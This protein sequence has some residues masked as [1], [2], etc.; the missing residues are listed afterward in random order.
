MIGKTPN[1]AREVRSDSRHRPLFILLLSQ[2]YHP[3]PLHSL[4]QFKNYFKTVIAKLF[5][6][7]SSGSSLDSTF[8]THVRYTFLN[9]IVRDDFDNDDAEE[10]RSGG[11]TSQKRNMRETQQFEECKSYETSLLNYHLYVTRKFRKS[12]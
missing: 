3:K 4:L 11:E 8:S 9:L 12:D 10:E 1:N 5:S 2:K 7:T 6:N